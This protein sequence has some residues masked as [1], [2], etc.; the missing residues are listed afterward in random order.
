MFIWISDSAVHLVKIPKKLLPTFQAFLLVTKNN[1]AYFCPVWHILKHSLA[2]FVFVILAIRITRAA[3]NWTK[4][5]FE[6]FPSPCLRAWQCLLAVMNKVGQCYYLSTD[7][8]ITAEQK[9]RGCPPW[10]S[11]T[12]QVSKETFVSNEWS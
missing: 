1:L 12:I 9:Q 3:T 6:N 11:L 7:V 2:W 5:D 8:V 4:Y 10:R